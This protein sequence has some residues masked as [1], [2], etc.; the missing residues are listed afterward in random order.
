MEKIKRENF[1]EHLARYQL[2]MVGRV[3][4]DALNDKQWF[5][6]ITMTQ[7]QFDEFMKYAIPLTKK[8]FKC[9]TSKA[10]RVLDW[11]NVNFG[12]RIYPTPIELNSLPIIKYDKNNKENQENLKMDSDSLA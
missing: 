4:E 12:L 2:E 1:A 3:W 9:N 5:Y 7:S 8:I 11:F 10:Q 6:N